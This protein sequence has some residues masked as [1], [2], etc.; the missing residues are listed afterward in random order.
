MAK[1]SLS[2]PLKVDTVSVP[3]ST[4]VIGLTFC[5][6]KQHRGL[7][8]GEWRRDL[9][10]DLDA[11]KA[12]GAAAL[13]TLMEEHEMAQ[14][15]VPATQLKS[16]TAARGLEWHHL[17]ITDVSVPGGAFED[18]WTYAGLRLAGLLRSGEK[19]VIHCLGGLGRTGTIAGRLLVELGVE[20]AA[21]VQMI[22][23][24]RKGS[25]E[26]SAQ[27]KYVLD[28]KRATGSSPARER[29]LACIL[30]GAIGDAF[31][32]A[33]EFKSLV[34]IR[35]A[36]GHEGLTEPVFYDGKLRVSD[37]T[38][39]TLFT[40]EGLLRA[41]SAGD[42]LIDSIRSAYLDWLETQD[43][44]G[45]ASRRPKT[46]WLARQPEMR[47]R[48]APGNTC[49]NSMRTG[50][51]GT[52]TQ[53]LNH[54]KGCGGVMRIAPLGLVREYAPEH[55]FKVAAEA[56]AL[57]HGHPSGYLSAG[58]LACILRH[59]VDGATLNAAI[60]ESLG[61]LS[62]YADSAET[63]RAVHHVQSAAKPLP[64]EPAV[65]EAL[66]GGWVGE[67]ALA[68]ALYSVLAANT[69]VESIRI[70]ANHSG[71]SDSTA[72]IAG[73]LWGAANG[74]DG[75]PADWVYALDLRSPLLHLSRQFLPLT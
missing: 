24:A 68:I 19:V 74:F 32:Y 9:C 43:E 60:E 41:T 57:T 1:T 12:F 20:P 67:E 45:T 11:I 73:Q 36:F 48:R 62:L 58:M 29:A 50:G 56:A 61:V 21:A 53:P 46:D 33:V 70:A 2:H 26:T 66:G 34:E 75:I 18:L 8:S 54:S 69:F 14:V 6:G 42:S 4:G 35:Q 37:D 3:E 7:N 38:Q 71:D 5:P 27:E 65:I 28:T 17:P 23:R 13:V 31:G 16:E 44:P 55:A 51:Q 30:A 15:H 49:L 59:L 52:V 22:R 63:A 47:F 40:L 10:I 64:V 25:I 72:A 39:M